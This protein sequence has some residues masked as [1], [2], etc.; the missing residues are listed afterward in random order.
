MSRGRSWWF[1]VAHQRATGMLVGLFNAN[2]RLKF[3]FDSRNVWKPDAFSWHCCH[4]N[5]AASRWG[6]ASSWL[7]S[8]THRRTPPVEGCWMYLWETGPERRRWWVVDASWRCS[9]S[10]WRRRQWTQSCHQ[11]IC[12]KMSGK[13]MLCVLLLFITL[14]WAEDAKMSGKTHNNTGKAGLFYDVKSQ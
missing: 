6:G 1:A 11:Q 14:S 2:V 9:G 3:F 5:H 13:V 12:G 8:C 4:G 7:H 10:C